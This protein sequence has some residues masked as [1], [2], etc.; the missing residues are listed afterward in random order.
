MWL[1]IAL[2]SFGMNAHNT[3]VRVV[4]HN[5]G[6]L[7]KALPAYVN[8]IP[9][10]ADLN[11]DPVLRFTI[12]DIAINVIDSET[13]NATADANANAYDTSEPQ[14]FTIS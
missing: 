14:I 2:W 10:N 8:N 1:L 4:S 5:N 12:L 3:A 11:A 9:S 13:Y 6:F 7:Y